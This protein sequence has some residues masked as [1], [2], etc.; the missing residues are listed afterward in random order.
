[1]TR[2]TDFLSL[3][4][5]DPR[6]RDAALTDLA[7]TALARLCAQTDEAGAAG[8]AAGVAARVLGEPCAAAMAYALCDPEDASAASLVEDLLDAGL[9]VEEL[10]RDYLA[11][12]ARR[13]GLLWDHDRLS[14]TEVAMATARI[15]SILRRMPNGRVVAR[16]SKGLGAVFAA[17]PGEMHTLGVMMTADLFRRRGWDISLFVGLAHDD[18]MARLIRDDRPVVGLSCSGDHSYPALRRLLAAIGNARPDVQILL[19]GQIISNADRVAAL[20]VPVM[21]VCDL[22]ATEAALERIKARMTAPKGGR[23]RSRQTRASSVA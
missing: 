20:P 12:A 18:L 10:C 19:S 8:V 15:Q 1:M 11:P 5:T 23:N 13:L 16:P 3:V 21:T 9:S 22:S 4:A 7:K 17:V 6:A 2:P 14:F